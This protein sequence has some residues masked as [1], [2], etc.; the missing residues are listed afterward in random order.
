[1]EFNWLPTSPLKLILKG[2]FCTGMI[3]VL[4]I[5]ILKSSITPI[6]KLIDIGLYSADIY[7]DAEFTKV[8]WQN[9][10]YIYFGISIGTICLSYLTTVLYLKK[11]M[12]QPVNWIKAIF[13]PIFI[14]KII[15]QKFLAV[16][17]FNSGK[18]LIVLE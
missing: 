6:F 2:C 18:L 15:F 5:S 9:C 17:P 14:I 16:L 4:M 10:H 11:A 12:H 1:M 13:Y 7:S 8:L 3:P